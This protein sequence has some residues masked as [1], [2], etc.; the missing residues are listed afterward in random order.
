MPL[1]EHASSPQDV[2]R[3]VPE[4]DVPA[5]LLGG[6]FRYSRGN[7]AAVAGLVIGA[8]VGLIAV[9]KV[10]GNPFAY[11]IAALLL[12]FLWI[13]QTMVIARF[14]P[15]NWLVRVTDR[16]LYIKF[17]SYLN[18]HF[19]ESDATVVYV[20]FRDVRLTTV[21]RELQEVPDSDGRGT[22]T[23]RRTV[24]EI[25]LKDDVPEIGKA[26]ASERRAE[27]P[28][29]ARWYGSTA[30]KY[31]HYPVSMPTPRIIAVEWG[32]KPR[33]PV[34]LS[35]MAVHAPVAASETTRDYTALGA[36]KQHEQE[37]RL[38]EL[39]EQGQVVDAIRVARSIYGYDLTQARDFVE[40]LAGRAKA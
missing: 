8:A 34:F 29:V 12:V 15:T 36:L 31:R 37:S 1:P 16:G 13:Y 9:A 19:P 4:A 7:A 20:P 17:R 5:A 39:M 22:S 38:L 6:S 28:K 23:R 11:Y 24:V 14:L 26:L 30:G 18:H 10:Q 3:L 32:V 25:E 33:A 2:I 27:A 40:G 21:V 35:V